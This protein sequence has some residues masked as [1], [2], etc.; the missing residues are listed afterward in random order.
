MSTLQRDMI[1]KHLR[2]HGPITQN[3]ALSLYSVGRLADV[4]FK[5]RGMGFPIV[6]TTVKGKNKFGRKIKWG[7]YRLVRRSQL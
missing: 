2:K 6:T 5:L 1:Y 3:E 4:I 7:S